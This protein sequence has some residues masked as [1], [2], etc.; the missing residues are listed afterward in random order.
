MT[1]VATFG[2]AYAGKV[3]FC[4]ARGGDSEI[5]VAFGECSGHTRVARIDGV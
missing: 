4:A 3:N 2:L 1:K 5:L